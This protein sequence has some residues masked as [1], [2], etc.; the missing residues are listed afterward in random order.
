[1]SDMLRWSDQAFGGPGSL[2][3][4][5]IVHIAGTKGKGT[6]CSYIDTLLSAHQKETGFPRRIGLYTS[7]HLLLVRER[8]RIDSKPITE[9]KFA[10]YF[11]QLWEKL[12]DTSSMPS[13]FRFL[14]LLAMHSF[15]QEKVD[16]V[17]L[18]TGVGGE[19]DST[20]IVKRPVATGITALGMDHVQFWM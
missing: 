19:F 11:F 18:E 16:A 13:Y 15:L 2:D 4:F 3:R 17:I 6:A 12:R 9:E 8:I 7:P 5:R 10:T 20:N 1:M 14:T